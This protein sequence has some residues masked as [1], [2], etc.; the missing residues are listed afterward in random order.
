MVGAERPDEAQA[1]RLILGP[2]A[3]GCPGPRRPGQAL[4]FTAPKW[5]SNARAGGRESGMP[6]HAWGPGG[7]EELLPRLR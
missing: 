4:D 7:R 6:E 3:K 2:S 1:V 5:L